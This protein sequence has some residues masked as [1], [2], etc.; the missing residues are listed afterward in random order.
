MPSD[1][2]PFSLR[3]N[4]VV[5]FGGT[6]LLGSALVRA[7]AAAGATLVVA[8]R[9]RESMETIVAGMG[10]AGREV[11]VEEVDVASENSIVEMR[12]RVLA[13]H[14]RID[15]MVYNAVT[16]PMRSNDDPL[17]AWEESMVVNATGAF[18][19]MRAIGDSMARQGTGSIVGISSMYGMVGSNLFLYEGTPTTVPPDYFFHKAGMINLA[20]Y[21]AAHYGRNGVRVNTV[22]PG[23]IFNPDKPQAPAFLERYNKLTSLGRMADAEDLGGPVV[24]LLGDASVYVTGTNL[25]VDGGYT[26]R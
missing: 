15:G 12:D 23:G 5:Q 16:R 22:S 6:G 3:G 24:F 2:S 26:A 21:L 17:S 1:P 7:I 13:A 10:E 18:A 8:S 11:H 9:S 20:R 25:P 4:V 14:G 19:A